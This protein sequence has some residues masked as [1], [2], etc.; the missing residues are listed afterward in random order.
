MQKYIFEIKFVVIII[1]PT[2]FIGL[3]VCSYLMFTVFQVA[4][5]CYKNEVPFGRKE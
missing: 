1:T 4:E 5:H 2:I 3:D